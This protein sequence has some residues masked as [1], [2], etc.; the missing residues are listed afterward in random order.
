MA[1][2]SPSSRR[3]GEPVRLV[4]A[5]GTP[6]S[7]PAVWAAFARQGRW[8]NGVIAG[9]LALLF[10]LAAAVIGLSTQPPDVV[11]V[12]PDGKSTY[13]N[14]SLDNLD[15]SRFLAEQRQRPS[16]V[17]ISHFS[18]DFLESMVAIDSGLIE[19]QWEKSLSMMSPSCRARAQREA[20][21]TRLIE[22]TKAL[23]ISTSVTFEEVSLVEQLPKAVHVHARLLR[24]RRH[25]TDSSEA[26]DRLVVD[27]IEDVVPRSPTFPDGLAVGE[28]RLKILDASPSP[29]NGTSSHAP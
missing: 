25:F 14:R 9:Q 17:T 5:A 19:H 2:P 15:L 16:D 8:K 27:L 13:V 6:L 21:A 18:R 7:P 29:S 22:T 26:V 23:R 1:T 20:T 3:P 11:L 10:C 24:R 4:Q 12:S 28:Y